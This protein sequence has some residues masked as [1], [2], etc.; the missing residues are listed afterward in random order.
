MIYYMKKVPDRKKE[1]Q[2]IERLCF[3]VLAQFGSQGLGEAGSKGPALPICFAEKKRGRVALQLFERNILRA[4]GG[5]SL[6]DLR[7]LFSL[8]SRLQLYSSSD[9]S[10]AAAHFG[11]ATDENLPFEINPSPL[12]G[13]P[14]PDLEED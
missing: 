12:T 8:L 3:G 5:F 9:V 2:G 7:L 10:L 6:K 14:M 13:D 11:V 4:F 1:R